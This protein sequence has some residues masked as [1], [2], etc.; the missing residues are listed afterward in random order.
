V[1]RVLYIGGWGRS[2]STILAYAI[3]M[4]PGYAP[5]GELRFVWRSGVL[6]DDRCTCGAPF[7][8]CPWWRRV[9]DAAF[10]GWQAVDA[11]LLARAAVRACSPAVGT[12]SMLRPSASPHGPL[13]TYREATEALYRAIHSV[14]GCHTIIDSSKHPAY[15]AHLAS[16]PVLDLRLLHLVRDSRGVAQSWTKVL[17]RPDTQRPRQFPRFHPAASG[18][19]WTVSHLG[20]ELLA[21][22]QPAVRIRYESLAA[23]P[24]AQLAAA[25]RGLRLPGPAGEGD[26]VAEGVRIDGHHVLRANPLAHRGGTAPIV[27]D[28]AWR[29]EMTAR[30][31]A[32]SIL[33]TWPLLWRYGYLGA[34]G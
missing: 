34:D 8:G 26:L 1:S 30:D 14:S 19:R 25:L 13:R 2:G 15:A 9:G 3:G 17:M 16:L 4:L 10:G 27:E 5:V 12:R 7:S 32:L 11:E 24:T 33:L 29:T 18:V 22:R 6:D 20:V 23:D 31:R 21:R 28:G